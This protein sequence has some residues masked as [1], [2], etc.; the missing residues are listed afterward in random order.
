MRESGDRHAAMQPCNDTTNL[1][2]L[3][4]TIRCETNGTQNLENILAAWSVRGI[5]VVQDRERLFRLHV[6]TAC[7]TWVS[8]PCMLQCFGAKEI[9]FDFIFVVAALTAFHAAS[10]VHC[11]QQTEGGSATWHP[12]PVTHPRSVVIPSPKLLGNCFCSFH[13]GKRICHMA[14]CHP[15]LSFD[16]IILLYQN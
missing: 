7:P 14:C 4:S 11:S 10:R 16:A 15:F 6:W 5:T 3:S 12:D 2:A 13:S 8:V 1:T 9:L